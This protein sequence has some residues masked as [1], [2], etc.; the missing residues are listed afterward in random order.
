MSGTKRKAALRRA[1]Q[2]WHE[3]WRRREQAIQKQL[4]DP[5]WRARS[6]IALDLPPCPPHPNHIRI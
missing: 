1:H 5:A 2:A 3:E 6:R 4:G